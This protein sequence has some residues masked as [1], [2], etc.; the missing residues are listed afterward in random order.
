MMDAVTRPVEHDAREGVRLGVVVATSTWLWL[1]VVDAVVGQ[2]FH[3]FTVLGG[4]VVFTAVHYLLNVAYG[5]VIVSAARAAEREPC[6]MLAL[7][8]GFLMFECA[9]AMLTV[10]LSHLG[11]GEL[12]WVRI[13]G[14]TLLGATVAILVLARRHPLAAQ[15]HR[16]EVES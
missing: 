15:L 13:F 10:L 4:V 14:G 9:A 3:T 11:L 16:A 1:A 12:A 7:V 6:A 2:P 8:F 5:T